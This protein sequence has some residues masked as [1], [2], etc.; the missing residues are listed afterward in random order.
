MRIASWLAALE[1]SNCWG[2]VG[3]DHRAIAHN[4][5]SLHHIFQ[6]PHISGPGI[7][8]KDPH[9]VRLHLLNGFLVGGAVQSKEVLNQDRDIARRAPAAAAPGSERR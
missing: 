1:E 2:S 5:Q 3:G 9:N 8:L 7:G 6:F 4:D